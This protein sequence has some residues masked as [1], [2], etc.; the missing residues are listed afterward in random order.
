MIKQPRPEDD[1]LELLMMM[2]ATMMMMMMEAAAEGQKAK[3]RNGSRKK[4]KGK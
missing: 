1:G 3:N 4:V 2:M